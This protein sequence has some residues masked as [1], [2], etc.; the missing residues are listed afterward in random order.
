[1]NHS[2]EMARL[3]IEALEDKKAEEIWEKEGFDSVDN[4]LY[5]DKDIT[6]IY[7]AVI[8]E[9]SGNIEKLEGQLR[10]QEII[11]SIN[12]ETLRQERLRNSKE[13]KANEN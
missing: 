9:Q 7:E 13:V 1:M 4:A 10:T 12:L 2:A 8:E 3:A 11:N 6:K 5:T